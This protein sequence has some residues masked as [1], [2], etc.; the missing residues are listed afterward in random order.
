MIFIEMLATGI[1][2]M[3]NFINLLTDKQQLKTCELQPYLLQSHLE[4]TSFKDK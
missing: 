2:F 1:K 4:A 3:Y